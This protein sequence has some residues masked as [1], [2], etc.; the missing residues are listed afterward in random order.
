M[1]THSILGNTR[2]PDISFFASGKIDITSRIV[3]ALGMVEGDVIDIMAGDGEYFLYV[4]SHASS[5]CGRHEAQCYP[6]KHGSRH[7]RAN[8]RRLCA[9]ILKASGSDLHAS[10]A[11][12]D[13]VQVNNRKAIPI[14]ILKNFRP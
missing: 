13:V 4:S 9:A 10:F 14:I 6:S 2:R 12:G 7:F 5:L 11:A 8:S 1:T 3:K